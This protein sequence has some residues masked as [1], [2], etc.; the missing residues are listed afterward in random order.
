MGSNSV[1]VLLW[2]VR[3]VLLGVE[4][5]P[6]CFLRRR[7]GLTGLLV[8]YLIGLLR[9]GREPSIRLGVQVLLG[10]LLH[11]YLLDLLVRGWLLVGRLS[12]V[13]KCGLDAL[14]KSLVSIT[15]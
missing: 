11:R 14:G 4:R 1:E 15:A 12:L 13:T 10:T 7:A 8:G 5:V 2:V 9:L 6:L 3:G